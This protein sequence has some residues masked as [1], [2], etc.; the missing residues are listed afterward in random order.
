MRERVCAC[1]CLFF[2]GY[3][4]IE[5]RVP[6]SSG[7]KSGSVMSGMEATIPLNFV[8][9]SRISCSSLVCFRRYSFRFSIKKYEHKYP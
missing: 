4:I 8:K 1:V 3:L 9:E 2:T 7:S 5:Q 6:C